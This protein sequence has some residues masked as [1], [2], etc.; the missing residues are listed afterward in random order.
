MKKLFFILAA[1][2]AT[3]TS[4]QATGCGKASTPTETQE[5]PIDT[6]A[7]KVDNE[8]ATQGKIIHLTKA[9]FLKK[10][11]NYEKNP[12]KWIYLG[13]QPAIVDFYA[14]WCA[15][16]RQIAPSLEQLAAEYSGKIT[17]YKINVDK[18]EEL[19]AAFGIRSIPTLLFIPMKGAPHTLMGA[20]PKEDLKKVIDNILLVK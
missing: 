20:Q 8:K 19:A 4:L 7:A 18:E 11:V 6:I 1:G 16:C 12:D 14:D 15:P 17:V 3:F 10:V 13:K 5:A 9:E 2:M